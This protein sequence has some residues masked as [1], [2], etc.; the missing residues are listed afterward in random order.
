MPFNTR[1]QEIY[2]VFAVEECDDNLVEKSK[3]KW[4][5]EW[6]KR[7]GIDGRHVLKV[8]CVRKLIFRFFLTYIYTLSALSVLFFLFWWFIDPSGYIGIV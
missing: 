2:V 7:K 8:K 4:T 1:Y 3:V 6:L 5:I